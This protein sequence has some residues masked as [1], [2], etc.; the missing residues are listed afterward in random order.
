MKKPTDSSIVNACLKYLALRKIPAWR[1]NAGA[2]VLTD[3]AGKRR[4]FRGGPAGSAD[5]LGIVPELPE[6]AV[7]E[8]GAGA[9]GGDAGAGAAVPDAAASP[10]A[11]EAPPPAPLDAAV[12]A[13]PWQ[14]SRRG[15]FLAVECKVPGGKVSESQRAFLDAVAAAGGLAVVVTSVKELETALGRE[16]NPSLQ[17]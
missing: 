7:P 15:V 13:R 2:F 8:P 10:A 1:N 5:I 6:V 17:G 4:R 3:A 9:G 16:E 12:A 14:P 11:P